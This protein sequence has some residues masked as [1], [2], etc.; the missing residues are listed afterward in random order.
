MNA[1][2]RRNGS[3]FVLNVRYIV[4]HKSHKTL[5]LLPVGFDG[6]GWVDIYIIDER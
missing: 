5:I 3:H 2:W 6:G 4:L 1:R